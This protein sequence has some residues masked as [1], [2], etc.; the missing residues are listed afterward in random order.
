MRRPIIYGML[1]VLC[2]TSCDGSVIPRM[3]VVATYGVG[4]FSYKIPS[5]T[6][7]CHCLNGQRAFR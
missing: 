1:L 5:Q 2:R 4:H 6:A 7:R 3:G